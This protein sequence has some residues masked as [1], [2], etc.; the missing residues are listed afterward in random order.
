MRQRRQLPPHFSVQERAHVLAISYKTSACMREVNYYITM[1]DL[2]PTMNRDLMVGKRLAVLIFTKRGR[3][4]NDFYTFAYFTNCALV[5]Y[6][7]LIRKIFAACFARATIRTNILPP[8]SIN[9]SYAL[10]N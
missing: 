8:H 3:K 9:P 10:V 6:E 4:G 7:Y 5:S 1:T 2:T